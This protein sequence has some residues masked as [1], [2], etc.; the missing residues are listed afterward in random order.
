MAKKGAIGRQM[1]DWRHSL[2]Q[3]WAALRFGEVKVETKGGQHVF[4]IQ[5]YLHDL[6]ANAISVELNA[7]GGDGGSPVRQEMKRV[8]QLPGAPGGYGYSAA[9]SADRPPADYTARM[10][11]HRDGVAIPLESAQILWQR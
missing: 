11:P 8:R 3:K 1:F 10:I 2:E 4:D 5:V 7:D 6:D 9:V